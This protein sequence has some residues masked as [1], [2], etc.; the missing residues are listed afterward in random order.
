LVLELE[1][2]FEGTIKPVK[3]GASISVEDGF[4]LAVRFSMSPHLLEMLATYI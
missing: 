2:I 4:A 3:C 1:H